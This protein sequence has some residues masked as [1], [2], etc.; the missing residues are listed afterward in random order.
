M[1]QLFILKHSMLSLRKAIFAC[2]SILRLHFSQFIGV[3]ILNKIVIAFLSYCFSPTGI[4]LLFLLLKTRPWYTPSVWYWSNKLQQQN[5]LIIEFPESQFVFPFWNY[6]SIRDNTK[7]L[8]D[9]IWFNK[10]PMKENNLARIQGILYC[11]YPRPNLP[12][13]RG[14]WFYRLEDKR[15]W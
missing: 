7:V 8:P 1:S 10:V 13:S 9:L 3:Q 6:G 4:M 5:T 11:L 12:K 15:W 2:Q 14:K